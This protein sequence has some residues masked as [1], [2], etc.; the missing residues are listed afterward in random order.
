MKARWPTIRFVLTTGWGAE[1]D[2]EAAR[3]RGVDAILA[4]PYTLSDLQRVIDR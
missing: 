3:R 4:K 1:L 2:A